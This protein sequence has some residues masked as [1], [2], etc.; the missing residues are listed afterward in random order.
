MN[1]V[2]EKAEC[3]IQYKSTNWDDL[4]LPNKCFWICQH[5]GLWIILI[6]VEIPPH[7]WVVPP[8]ELKCDGTF[9][10]GGWTVNNNYHTL[11]FNGIEADKPPL[12]SCCHIFP[13]LM[14]W[15]F[16]LRATGAL[17]SIYNLTHFPLILILSYLYL[18]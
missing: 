2:K 6:E 18:L 11:L 14:A 16:K 8:Q 13:A 15:N 10:R 5:S 7:L 17:Y 4:D 3:I 1:F 9:K 12:R